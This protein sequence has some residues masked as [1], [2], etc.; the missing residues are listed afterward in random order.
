MTLCINPRCTQPENPDNAQF[1]QNCQSA[2]LLKQ[3]YRATKV[4]GGGGFGKTYD[5]SDLGTRNKV[6][7]VLINNSPKAVELFQREAEF[8]ST[9]NSAGI[10]KAEKGSYFVFQPHDEQ[11]PV[12]CLVM[13][14]I[15]GM[16]LRDYLKQLGHPIDSETAKRWLEELALILQEVHGQGVLHRDIKP[17]NIIF[18]PD[19]TLALIDFGAVREGTGTEVATAAKGGTEVA[20]HVAGGTSVVSAGYT[21]PEQMNGEALKQSDIYSLGKTFIFLLTGKEPSEISYNPHEDVLQWRK[22]APNVETNLATLIDQ[23]TSM[24]VRQRP[25]SIQDLLKV[26]NFKQSPTTPTSPKPKPTPSSP[27]SQSIHPKPSSPQPLPT[28]QRKTPWFG[29]LALVGVGIVGIG[30][31]VISQ[32]ASYQNPVSDNPGS[33]NPVVSDYP[34][35]TC[36]S[37][38]TSYQVYVDDPSQK[39]YIR[40]NFC[41]DAWIKNYEG[42]Q[43]VQVA[44]FGSETDAQSFAN[45]LKQQNVVN[46]FYAAKA[47]SEPVPPVPQ[48][49]NNSAPYCRETL[50]AGCLNDDGT[51]AVYW[52]C[53]ADGQLEQRI[54]LPQGQFPNSDPIYAQNH[55]K[56]F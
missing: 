15:E 8:L 5:V 11:A 33:P 32:N 17:Q 43:V 22:Y 53:F 56:S 36:G 29:I 50:K 46:A 49:V 6:L 39:D 37:G 41:G 9:H 27:S 35:G 13:E 44:Q 54:A 26:L 31:F 48:Q 16:N 47:S 3:R 45:F 14:K 2:L 24:L 34:K 12:H 23:M 18:K 40:S 20:S 21:A 55:C 4:L 10:P 28:P 19:C 52:E 1:C 51:V 25:A 30:A 7:K 38:G 42:R